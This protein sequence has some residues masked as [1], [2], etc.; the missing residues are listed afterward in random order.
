[1]GW[2][3]ILSANV[4]VVIVSPGVLIIDFWN[5]KVLNVAPGPGNLISDQEV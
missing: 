5:V 2:V 3:S 4:Y 1:V